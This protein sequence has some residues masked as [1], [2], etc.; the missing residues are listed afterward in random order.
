MEFD[1][2]AFGNRLCDMR[3]EMQMSPER[4]SEI[5]GVHKSFVR[6][7]ETA[8]KVP[9]LELFVRMCNLL[10]AS[11]NYLL[12][13]SLTW[14]MEDR[15]SSLDERLQELSPMQF[16]FIVDMVETMI[17]KFSEKAAYM[18]GKSLSGV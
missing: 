16:E 3:R 14:G 1:R 5:C 9:S 17:D 18:A 8:L 2:S 12:K 15:L 7:M 6:Q 10:Q 13:N 4:F 11:P